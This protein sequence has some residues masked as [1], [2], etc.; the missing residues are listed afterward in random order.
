LIEAFAYRSNV[1]SADLRRP[2]MK[3]LSPAL[4]RTAVGF[5]VAYGAA[6]GTSF[7]GALALP[8]LVDAQT[9]GILELALSVGAIAAS[10][11]GLSAP[12]AAARAHLV[13]NDPQATRMLA[14]YC[15]WLSTIGLVASAAMAA[16]GLDADYV[17]CA[18]IL[19]VYALQFSTSTYTRMNGLIRLSG[20]F[21]HL[22]LLATTVV[23][24]VL[25][26]VAM[27]TPIAF[28]WS[29]AALT[30]M[31][32]VASARA[33]N[34][35]SLRELAT[36]ARRVIRVG[37]PMMFYGFTLMAIFSTP[38][39][40][41]AMVSSITDVAT[42]SLCSRLALVVILIHQLLSTGFF[43]Q[44]YQLEKERVT[45]VLAAW[46]V[47]ISG[48][49]VVVAVIARYTA[50][51]LVIGTSVPAAAI[52]PIF[53]AIIVQTLLWVL[54]ANLE[55]FVNRE[56]ISH[57]AAIAM[58]GPIAVAAAIGWWLHTTGHLSLATIIDVYTGLILTSLLTQMFLLAREGFPFKRCYAVLPLTAAPLLVLLL[59]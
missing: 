8:R 23:A 56:L 35:T 43:R 42:F 59:P 46:I 55:I 49:G 5:V 38:R 37:G 21:D 16:S 44:L 7:V 6:K 36:L 57:R 47:A 33:L 41:I 53:P 11:L 3:S 58:V 14:G 10:V 27:A 51:W 12:G 2:D 18:A 1:V 28:A 31:A 4:V 34:G 30:A 39:I 15:C 40:V 26:A 22:A 50:D 19:G 9:Y 52:I 45:A 48:V 29:F 54:N 13:D 24:I 17:V 32:V 25:V 20:W